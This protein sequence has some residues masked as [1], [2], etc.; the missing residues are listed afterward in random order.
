MTSW[1]TNTWLPRKDTRW[2]PIW[3][4]FICISVIIFVAWIYR[5]IWKRIVAKRLNC[6]RLPAFYWRTRK[7]MKS[8]KR[9]MKLWIAE[10]ISS[11]KNFTAQMLRFDASTRPE[12]MDNICILLLQ[13]LVFFFVRLIRFLIISEKSPCCYKYVHFWIAQ[14]CK[15]QWNRRMN[16]SYKL[17]YLS[18]FLLT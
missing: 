11:C 18:F 15:L 16:A 17:D 3:F 14:S 10:K 9:L 5:S 1:E 2:S 13:L 6:Y 7:L 8:L 12:E 4:F